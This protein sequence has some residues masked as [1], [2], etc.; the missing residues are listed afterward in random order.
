MYLYP[1]DTKSFRNKSGKLITHA[2]DAHVERGK[3][4]YLKFKHLLD[5]N[6]TYKELELEQIIKA[7]TPDGYNY[8][9]VWD[10]KKMTDHIEVIA[11]QLMYDFDNKLVKPFTVKGVTGRAVIDVFKS[12]LKTPLDTFTIDSSITDVYDF[13]L[14]ERSN[15]YNALEVLQ[16]IAKTWGGELLVNGYDIRLIPRLGKKTNALLHERKNIASFEDNTTVEELITRIHISSTWRPER[17][18][19]EDKKQL[20][21]GGKGY[22]PLEEITISTTVDSPLIN[23][24]SQVY[25]ASFENNDLRTEQELIEW[26]RNKFNL[27]NVDKPKRTIK[28]TTNI[29]DGTVINYG[30]DLVLHYSLHDVRE[31]IRCIGYDYDPISGNYYEIT[32]GD[33]EESFR[34]SMVSGVSTAVKQTD[35]LQH[36]LDKLNNEVQLVTQMANSINRRTFGEKPVPNPIKGDLWFKHG[37]G[38]PHQVTILEYDGMKWVTVVD[39]FIGERVDEQINRVDKSVS[40]LSSSIENARQKAEQA[41][42]QTERQTEKSRMHVNLLGENGLDVYPKNRAWVEGTEPGAGVDEYNLEVEDK[43]FKIKHNGVGFT[44]GVPYTLSFRVDSKPREQI[45]ELGR[46]NIVRYAQQ[47]FMGYAPWISSE[48]PVDIVNKLDGKK[49]VGIIIDG[50]EYR[51]KNGRLSLRKDAHESYTIHRNYKHML[52]YA[53]KD[54]NNFVNDIP[55]S[56][57]KARQL[58]DI[59]LIVLHNQS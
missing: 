54:G 36:E 42:R 15:S 34:D 46:I 27:E 14:E 32:L 21:S 3:G 7:K 23:E 9:R 4:F 40:D 18:K 1:K 55:I 37:K 2:Y 17:D 50:T 58:K 57:R 6:E 8:F 53:T 44:T 47:S 39:D 19:G 56:G 28:L 52:V 49:I 31:I 51:P 59:Q 5:D 16:K 20:A 25:D 48:L 45:I 24:Y 35:S 33:F 11:L 41:L 38:R 22:E 30:D 29:V 26:A 43:T 10:I 13:E 12:K